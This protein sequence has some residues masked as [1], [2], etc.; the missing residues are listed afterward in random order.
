MGVENR[1]AM[2]GSNDIQGPLAKRWL[3]ERQ[4]EKC[5][6]VVGPMLCVEP[7]HI[8]YIVLVTFKEKYEMDQ[9]SLTKSALSRMC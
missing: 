2:L 4:R 5:G 8:R 7:E 3:H 9:Q 1:V 6:K